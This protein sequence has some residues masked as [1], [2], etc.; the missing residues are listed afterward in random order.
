MLP[1]IL[2]LIIHVYTCLFDVDFYDY[3]KYENYQQTRFY[4]NCLILLAG[5]DKEKSAKIRGV[6]TALKTQL[7]DVSSQKKTTFCFLKS[8]I[9]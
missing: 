5:W 6:A 3:E 1:S 9:F 8:L 4:F 2:S 7:L